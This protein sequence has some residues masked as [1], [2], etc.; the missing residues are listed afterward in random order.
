[1]D[2]LR[3]L[4]KY[5]FLNIIRS[6]WVLV[7]TILLAA[8][9]GLFL[10][11]SG[12]ASKALATVSMVMVILVPL[13]TILFSSFYWY[14]SDRF[15]E[16]LLSQALSRR[17]VF[18]ARVLALTSTLGLSFVFGSGLPFMVT[19]EF[20]LALFSTLLLGMFL[21][22]VFCS[23]GVLLAI[24]INDR[25]RGM[26]AA[27]GLWFYFSILHDS[28]ILVILLLMK[29]SPMDLPASVLGTLNPIGLVRVVLLVQQ[30][31]SMLLGHTGALVRQTLISYTGALWAFVVGVLWI[32]IP[33][34]FGLRRF[35]KKD[36]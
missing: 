6:R 24:V 17:T 33:F 21:S 28:L 36:I 20:S 29:D 14:N 26:G 7:Y 35:F 8:L 11:L 10:H 30:D 32:V 27:F 4:F 5:E 15:T 9:S 16:L 31:A 12:E 18:S 19:G 2:S 22:F 3:R 34:L 23:L 1:M 25:M 13:T